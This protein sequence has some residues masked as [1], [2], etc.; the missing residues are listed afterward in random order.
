[1]LYNLIDAAQYIER[2]G[3]KITFARLM[4]IMMMMMMMMMI[5]IIIYLLFKV[6]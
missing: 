3:T 6:D 4:I 2:A 1:M 5:K